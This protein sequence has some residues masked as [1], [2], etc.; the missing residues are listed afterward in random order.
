MKL[1]PAMVHVAI[2][3][4]NG[5]ML[6]LS[7]QVISGHLLSPLVIVY[8]LPTLHVLPHAVK[9]CLLS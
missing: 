9:F 6:V 5:Q 8:G 2:A 1:S 7:V 4:L 3:A